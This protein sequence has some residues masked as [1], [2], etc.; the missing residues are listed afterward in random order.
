M[1][2]AQYYLGVTYDALSEKGKAQAVFADAARLG[3]QISPPPLDL[4]FA[5]VE[6]GHT[7]DAIA[8]YLQQLAA[9]ETPELHAY[10]GALYAENG[11]T[12]LARQEYKRA[13]ELNAQHPLAHFS[14]AK[15]A[16]AESDW[17]TAAAEYE[18]YLVGDKSASAHDYAAQAYLQLGDLALRLR[19]VDPAIYL[20]R[21]QL[22][23][24]RCDIA[25]AVADLERSAEISP[26]SRSTPAALGGTT[27]RRDRMR[28]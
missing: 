24:K 8:I 15:L 19:P 4:A 28:R 21:G 16:F 7:D 9:Q 6:L 1:M 2:K 22:V 11:A 25:Q 18:A 17:H 13:V 26:P 3:E 12:E 23:Y 14:L 20:T 5:Y 27:P 10:L